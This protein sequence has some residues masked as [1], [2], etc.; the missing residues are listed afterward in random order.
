MKEYDEYLFF[1]YEGYLD[2]K[3]EQEELEEVN[4]FKEDY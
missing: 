1:D 3:Q 4:L 2:R